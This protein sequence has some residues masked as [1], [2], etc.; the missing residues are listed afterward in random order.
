MLSGKA[1]RLLLDKFMKSEVAKS[2]RVQVVLPN[3]KFYD[4]TGV[5]LLENKLIG[6]RETHRIALTIRP[7]NGWE[8]GKVTKKL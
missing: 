1:L 4:V 7:E 5:Q 3:G 8:M 6:A 2:S